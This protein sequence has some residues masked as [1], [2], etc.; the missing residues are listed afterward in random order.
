MD[1]KKVESL[2]RLMRKHNMFEVFIEDKES[3]EKLRITGDN[4]AVQQ[5]LHDYVPQAPAPMRSIGAEAGVGAPVSIAD[6]GGGPKLKPNQKLIRSPFVGTYYEAPSPGAD[7]FVKIGQKVHKGDVLCIVEA[8]KLMNEIESDHDGIL[9]E[10]LVANG[11]AI[12]FDQPLFVV[13]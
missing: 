3:G 6:E 2:M 7:A 11:Q 5:R 12:E 9:L 1:I 4:P 13:E 8:M 10:S